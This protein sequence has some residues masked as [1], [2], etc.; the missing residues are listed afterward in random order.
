M[1]SFEEYALSS[2]EMELK[3][4]INDL[5]Q[6]EKLL[7]GSLKCSRIYHY[8]DSYG[9][10]GILQNQ[11]FF[12]T[13]AAFLNDCTELQY[14]KD[15]FIQELQNRLVQE[16]STLEKKGI[17][18]KMIEAI[19]SITGNNYYLICFSAHEDDLNQWIKYGDAG[20]GF[21]LGF[22][23]SWLNTFF[24]VYAHIF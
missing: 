5:I 18:Y 6:F 7:K 21:C 8:T 24:G 3:N 9:L 15:I 1:T 17:L 10:T 23:R 4:T 14:G 19:Q 2:Y 13:N 12:A 16:N 20:K 11:V 22:E